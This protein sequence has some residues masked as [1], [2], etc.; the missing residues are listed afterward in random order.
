ME[1]KGMFI[2]DSYLFT[3]VGAHFLLR[4]FFFQT[5]VIWLTAYETVALDLLE[6]ELDGLLELLNFDS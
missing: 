6:S 4:N 5:W 1:V 3:Y 2:V